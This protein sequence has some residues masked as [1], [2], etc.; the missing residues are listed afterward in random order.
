MKNARQISY[1]SFLGEEIFGDIFSRLPVIP[2]RNPGCF[3]K[4]TEPCMSEY[5]V[6]GSIHGLVCLTTTC[7]HKLICLW[8]PSINQF[9]IL[10]MHSINLQK[11]HKCNTT[12]LYVRSPLNFPFARCSTIAEH[13]GHFAP[14]KNTRQ[15]S[16]ISFLGKEI[17]R[18]IF[19]RLPVKTLLHL[20]FVCKRWCTLISTPCFISLH[21]KRFS[22]DPDNHYILV[23]TRERNGLIRIRNPGYFIK[24][25]DY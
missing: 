17:R 9:K 1:I 23:W 8:N 22:S 4:L 19:S 15:I 18:D 5:S 16:Y 20:K 10:P 24:L 11:A 13:L 3:I 12:S 6:V 7:S 25:T 14:K 2:I 21:L